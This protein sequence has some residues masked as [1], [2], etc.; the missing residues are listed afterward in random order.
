MS[1]RTVVILSGGLDS[2]VLL[3]HLLDHPDFTPI[4]ALSFDYGQ[5]HIQEVSRAAAL[6]E[7]LSV[8]HRTIHLNDLGNHLKS[9]LTTPG[10]Q[11]PEGHYEEE[12]M[13]QTVVPF[14]NTIFLSI[15]AGR[16][17]SENCDVVAFGAHK[18]DHAIYPDCRPEFVFKLEE[19][20]QLADWTSVALVAPLLH[21]TKTQVVQIGHKLEVPFNKTWSC[22]KGG[23]KHCGKCGT[24]VE[25][26]EAFELAG[27]KDPVE[28]EPSEA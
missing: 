17:V 19:A 21:M 13:K 8:R 26:K 12:S 11:V 20:W 14:R 16:A 25:R 3:Y 22:Y 24:C 7:N 2:A 27:L 4:E 6:C 23:E 15:A 1:R 18:S 10:Q 5:R 28:Y 9:A